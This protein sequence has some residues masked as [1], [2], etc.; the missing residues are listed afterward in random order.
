MTN[1]KAIA[2]LA[3]GAV[4][5]QQGNWQ[6][7]DL[8]FA[9]RWG[10]PGGRLRV[11]AAYYLYQQ[12]P[13]YSVIASGGK[14]WEIKDKDLPPLS[15]IIEKEL[16][17]LGVSADKIIK[18]ENSSKTFSQLMELKKVIAENKFDSVMILS[19]L[20]HLPRIEAMVK[21]DQYLKEMFDN[22]NLELV[23]AE[24]IL[25]QHDPQFWQPVIEEAYQSEEME[26]IMKQEGQGIRQIKEGTYQFN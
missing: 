15:E 18:E 24:D 1:R 20:Y 14:G 25:M 9:A 5:D 11:L 16:I 7:T 26:E 3:A 17:E 2:I 6:S 4:K 19:S 10:S 12:D 22:N 21:T 23:A 8:D 13:N